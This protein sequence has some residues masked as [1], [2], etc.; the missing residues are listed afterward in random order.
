MDVLKYI[1]LGFGI[2]IFGASTLVWISL[3]GYVLVKSTLVAAK[4]INSLFWTGVAGLILESDVKSEE[5]T[6]RDSETGAILKYKQYH[7][8]IS[9][10]YEVS[11]TKYKSQRISFA[12]DS[13]L[14]STTEENVKK[15]VLK[16]RPGMSVMVYCD[17]F[18]PKQSVLERGLKARI[19]YSFFLSLTFFSLIF[20]VIF[21]VVIS[22]WIRGAF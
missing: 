8:T 15:T 9:Y 3:W 21:L 19:L 13:P 17:L 6:Q 16:Y 18:K 14:F 5:S 1:L 10:S 11:C 20:A 2:L 7:S 12:D 22:D 4:S